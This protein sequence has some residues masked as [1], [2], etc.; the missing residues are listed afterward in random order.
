MSLRVCLITPPSPFLMDQRYFMSLGILKVGA[1]L[2]QSGIHVDHLDL[3]GIENYEDAVRDYPHDA[4]FA[5]TATTPQIPAAVKIRNVLVGRKVII[6][7]PH[8]TL[9][10][11]AAKRGSERAKQALSHILSTF[12]CVVAGDGEKSIFQALHSKGLIDA[13]DPKSVLWQTSKDFTESPWPARHLVD[14]DS[15]H[16]TVDGERA[17]SAVFQLGC[18]FHSVTGDTF[19]FTSKGF[20]RVDELQARLGVGVVEQC[21]H[22]DSVVRF[23]IAEPLA[24][25]DGARIASA[26]LDEGIRK[27]YEVRHKFGIPLRG[28]AE[29]PILTVNGNSL[30]WK[31]IN[32]LNN[33]DWIACKFPDPVSTELQTLTII[34]VL[35]VVPPGGFHSQP[36][37]LPTVVDEDLAWLMGFILG[38]GCIPM[39]GRPQIHVC[40]TEDIKVK[41]ERVV[42]EKFNLKL[43]IYDS[44][45]TT[46]MQHGWINSRVVYEFFV[47]T[48]GISPSNK[49]NVPDV[50]RRSP[51][52]VIEAFLNGLWDADGYDNKNGSYL[53]TINGEFARQICMLMLLIKQIPFLREIRG[54]GYT[55]GHHWRV[56]IVQGERLPLDCGI[57]KSKKSGVWYW[58]TKKSANRTGI[59]RRTLHESGLSNPLDIDGL[60]YSPVEN[61]VQAGKETVYDLTVPD[62][63]NFV[64]NGIIVH[65]CAF[66]GGRNSPMLRQIR[67]R[68]SDSVIAEMLHLH[69]RYGINAL[70]AYDDELNVNKQIVD[71]MRRIKATG[72]D[73]RLRGFVKSELFTEEQAEAMYA[74][75]FRWLLCGFESAHPRILKNIAKNAT[76]EDN[77]KM[78]RTAHKYGLKVKALM[79]IG[80]AGE[81]EETINATKNWLI[82]ERPDD[83][84]ATVICV[85]PGTNY[86]DN[87]VPIGDNVYKYEVNGDALYSENV[88]YIKELA[89]YKGHAGEYQSFVWTDHISRERIVTMRDELEH[90][91]RT[92]LG[93]PYPTAASVLNYEHST[94]MTP[95][96]YILR[97]SK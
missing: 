87:A 35:R 84:D 53:C 21:V 75:G 14:V 72:I 5:L 30:V 47:Q 76:V 9:V 89:Y 19:I 10:H 13:D 92:K 17:L 55:D 16:Y 51:R 48:L 40:V 56:G 90:E 23:D 18:P 83:F 22:G 42:L 44:T 25:R 69:E 31:Q 66:C 58:R 79:S 29:H 24:A 86:Y 26:F 34:P 97:S 68:T 60:F 57:Y 91:V 61:I 38:D 85:Y 43:K 71:L 46:K 50:I 49:L 1:V 39:D 63:E 81:S 96:P 73:W 78:L 54:G 65:N 3:S 41:L 93:I 67:T 27:V 37:K 64:A 80:H 2:E 20:E 95:P 36:I 88:D 4:I 33:G 52:P 11:A 70:M 82:E 32:E 12:D 94:G 59:R 6:G 8:A 15:Y 77:T 62:G 74:A 7:G 45:L 28:T